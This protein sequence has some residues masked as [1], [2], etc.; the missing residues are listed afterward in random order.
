MSV[1]GDFILHE[2]RGHVA[3]APGLLHVMRH[4][5]D[6]VVIF[7]IVHQIFD[8]RRRDRVERRTGLVHQDDFG[9]YG[10]SARDAEPLLLAA[11]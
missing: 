11:R 8:A 3:R 6:R 5:H 9:L 10:R 1:A 7:E 4:D 2:A